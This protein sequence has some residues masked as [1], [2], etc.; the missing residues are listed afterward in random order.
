MILEYI[1]DMLVE[2]CENCLSG[3]LRQPR[4]P[5]F[6]AFLQG[7]VIFYFHRATVVIRLSI[8]HD[9]SC[10]LLCRNMVATL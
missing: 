1:R 6:V 5:P 3:C 4:I 7:V 10:R 8:I 9:F 2:S